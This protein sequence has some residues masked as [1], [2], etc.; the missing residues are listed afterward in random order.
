MLDF[1]LQAQLDFLDWV[2]QGGIQIQN[3][4]K[5]QLNRIR[6]RIETYSD[7]PADLADASLLEVAE[8]LKIKSIITL[9]SDFSVYK[10]EDGQYLKNLLD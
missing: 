9:D 4:E 6:H 1:S 5:W 8:T 2:I 10:L 3:I 7:L